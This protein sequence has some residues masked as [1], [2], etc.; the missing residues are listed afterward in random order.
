MSY[1]KWKPSWY[2]MFW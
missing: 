1:H 2:C